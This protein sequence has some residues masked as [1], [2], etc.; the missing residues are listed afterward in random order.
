ME[1]GDAPA[2]ATKRGATKP[3]AAGVR[4]AWPAA[5]PEQVRA[6]ADVLSAAAGAVDEAALAQ[7]FTG[8]GPWKKRLPNILLTLEALGRVRREGAGWRA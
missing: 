1:L 6:V 8:R 3:A 4:R 2:S 7:S 5:L